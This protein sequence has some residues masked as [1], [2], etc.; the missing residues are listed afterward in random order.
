MI[1]IDDYKNQST[2]P[3]LVKGFVENM[4]TEVQ[5]RKQL[6]DNL[7]KGLIDQDVYN[8]AIDQ[9]ENLLVKGGG[10]GSKG[11]KVIGTTSSGKPIYEKNH[12]SM[13]DWS[14]QDHRDAAVH[15]EKAGNKKNA[16]V[17]KK[18]AGIIADSEAKKK[19]TYDRIAKIGNSIKKSEVNPDLIKAKSGE[20]SRGGHII[21]HTKSGKAVYADKKG[22][23]KDYKNFSIQDHSDA[24]DL[25]KNKVDKHVDNADDSKHEHVREQE[26]TLAIHHRDTMNSHSDAAVNISKKEHESGLSKDE[27]KILADQNKKQIEHHSKMEAFHTRMAGHATKEAFGVGFDKEQS[28]AAQ[29]AFKYHQSQAQ[30]HF[31]KQKELGQK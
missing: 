16:E 13:L 9:L 30:H 17:H 14:E 11:G 31:Q 25:H 12:P 27:K 23:H 8:K 24:F 6:S 7:S 18:V 20:G 15:H 10:L 4:P 5:I 2:N 29:E 3:H 22:D 1:T 28:N 21:G 19:E 26:K